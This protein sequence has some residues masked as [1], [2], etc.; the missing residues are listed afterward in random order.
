MYVI[1]ATFLIYSLYFAGNYDS[2]CFFQKLIVISQ[3][4][5]YLRTI[6]IFKE[7]TK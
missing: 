5:C 2:K 4:Y 7:F 6:T 1:I 3:Y